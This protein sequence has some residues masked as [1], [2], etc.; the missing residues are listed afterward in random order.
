MVNNASKLLDQYNNNT[1]TFIVHFTN[2]IA[3]LPKKFEELPLKLKK[4]GL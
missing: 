1:D 2:I 4:I 3:D